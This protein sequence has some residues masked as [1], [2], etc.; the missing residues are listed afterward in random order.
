MARDHRASRD[1]SARSSTCC[2]QK[3]ASPNQG[4]ARGKGRILPALR[5]PGGV[6]EHAHRAQCLDQPGLA[7]IECRRSA[8]SRP[9]ARSTG[10]AAH[11]GL[12]DRNIHRSW[13]AGPFR[14]SSRSTKHRALR[15][16][17][18]YCPGG[19]R[20]AAGSAPAARALDTLRTCPISRALTCCVAL[21]HVLAGT[22]PTP[23]PCGARAR[24]GA[25]RSSAGPGDEGPQRADRVDASERAAQQFARLGLVEVGRAT[26]AQRKG[27]EAKA[28]EMPQCGLAQHEQAPPP[29]SPPPPVR[30]AK[31]CSSRICASL[32]RPAAIELQHQRR[33]VL[34][35][36]AID[37]VFVAVEREQ[38][39][40]GR[41]APRPRRQPAPCRV[42][43]PQR[44]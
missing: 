9:A 17:R 22:A 23:A 40:I 31:A 8:G 2:S 18:G 41:R 7:M 20:R 26:R 28:L 12:P 27:R 33:R 21:V 32:Q 24:R 16:A 1:C 3:R 19:S 43:G 37:A 15:A 30:V 35:T 14:Q 36:D 6:V 29:E 42:S 13:I 39:A 11:P 44:A 10:G 25:R 34:A 4:K 5:N 38:M